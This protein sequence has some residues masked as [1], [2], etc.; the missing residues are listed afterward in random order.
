MKIQRAGVPLLLQPRPDI[1][2]RFSSSGVFFMLISRSSPTLTKPGITFSITGVRAM[3][4]SQSV[5]AWSASACC[6]A[7]RRG[8]APRSPPSR[9]CCPRCCARCLLVGFTMLRQACGVNRRAARGSLASCYPPCGMRPAASGRRALSLLVGFRV[10]HATG[11]SPEPVAG[12]G[13][14]AP[15]MP[16][17]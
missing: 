10:H 11:G 3:L 13:L 5:K 9:R 7:T 16:R 6:P 14:R 8:G 2:S 4:I 15:A 12:G 17:R 1:H